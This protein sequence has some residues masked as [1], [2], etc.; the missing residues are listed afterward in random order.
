RAAHLVAAAVARG[1]AAA[2]PAGLERYTDRIQESGVRIQKRYCRGLVHSSP[3]RG[4]GRAVARG[5][6]AGLRRPTT[7]DRRPTNDQRPT[8]NDEP[9]TPSPLHP[10]TRSAFDV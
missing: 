7:D 5:G 3:V 2:G 1:R 8:T 4:A 10:F 9:F 6:G